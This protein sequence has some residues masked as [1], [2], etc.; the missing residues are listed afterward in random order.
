MTRYQQ[1]K[2]VLEKFFPEASPEEI[3]KLDQTLWDAVFDCEE[4]WDKIYELIR[5]EGWQ[6]SD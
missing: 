6:E 2:E 5:N 3:A 4:V 1:F